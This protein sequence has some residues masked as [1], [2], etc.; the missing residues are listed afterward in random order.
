[1]ELI[2][3]M[4]R[5]FDLPARVAFWRSVPMLKGLSNKKDNSFPSGRNQ[6]EDMQTK[7]RGSQFPVVRMDRVNRSILYLT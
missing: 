3:Y 5:Q 7:N 6:F 4:S 2:H 1:M